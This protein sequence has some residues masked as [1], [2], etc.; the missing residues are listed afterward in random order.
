MKASGNASDSPDPA[1]VGELT[2]PREAEPELRAGRAGLD[3]AP[4][5]AHIGVWEWDV[6]RD[7]LSWVPGPAGIFAATRFGVKPASLPFEL[8]HP[9][10]AGR[11]MAEFKDAI[12]TRTALADEFRVILPGG[13]VRWVSSVGG[14]RYDARGTPLSV[15]G[16]VEDITEKRR[17]E[18]A[19]RARDQLMREA[20]QAARL[21]AWE[22]DLGT[23]ALREIGPVAELFG[24]PPGFVHADLEA[25]RASVHP[26]D[27]ERIWAMLPGG[28]A[29]RATCDVEF[30]T[31]GVDD[32]IRW[33]HAVGRTEYAADGTPLVARG[34]HVDVSDRK[35]AEV[36]LQEG[37]ERFRQLVDSVPHHVWA[38]DLEGHLAYLNRRWIEYTGEV[39]TLADPDSGWRKVVHP[40]DIDRVVEAWARAR[41][42][43]SEY[44]VDLRLRHR[45]GE[46]RWFDVRGT[47]TRDEQGR[48]ARWHGTNTDVHEARTMREA[49]RLEEERLARI[50]ELAPGVILV[51]QRLPD[52]TIRVPYASPGIQELV[53]IPA[54]ELARDASGIRAA[55]HP[56]DLPRAEASAAASA[57]TLSPWRYELRVRHPKRG[58]IWVEIHSMP[59]HDPDGA[60][61]WYGFL[62]DVTQRKRDEGELRNSR[63]QL[64][65]ALEAGGMAPWIYDISK[66]VIS[67]DDAT[68]KLWGR[69]RDELGDGSWATARSFIHPE[70]RLPADSRAAILQSGCR[71]R[72]EFRIR[73]PGGS[74]RWLAIRARVERDAAGE[75]LRLIGVMLD[76]TARKTAEAAQLRSQKLEALGTLAGGIAHDFNNILLAIG[77]N[78]EIGLAD[79][80]P[81][82]PV[83][84]C[85]AEIARASTRATDV[86]RQILAFSGPQDP[87]RR[88]LAPRSVVEEALRL[89]R[90]TIPATVELR[91]DF[92]PDLPAISADAGQIHQ[93]IVNLAT[94]AAA[95]IGSRS[96]R[97]DFRLDAADVGEL[98]RSLPDL[99][100]GRYV[101]LTVSDDGRGM[102][103]ETLEC[104]FDPFFSTK[105]PGQGS[106][107]G[108][109]VVHGIVKSH[110]GAISVASEPGKGATFR[111]YFPAVEGRVAEP[112]RPASEAAPRRH[113]RVLFIDDE[114][115]VVRAAGR[116]FATI[117][118]DATVFSDAA[119]ALEEFRSRPG[120]F[121]V[122]ITDRSMPGVSGF[123]LARDLLAV[124]PDVPILMTT[125]YVHP[126][127]EEI[128]RQ[129][130]VRELI[131]KPF[132]TEQLAR[133]LDRC[134]GRGR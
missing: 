23:G 38:I 3:L 45:D 91:A 125:G 54:E 99:H 20:L 105:P 48:I 14:A 101:R 110:G 74:W 16:T 25:L 132:S 127:D 28:V 71:I 46:Y 10:D 66:D 116:L 80:P 98:A 62:S 130:G 73:L 39:S 67:W 131:P 109:A 57:A 27:G 104:V 129:I 70:D 68:L 30:R 75:P 59:T 36:T 111:L 102:D 8:L 124:R 53:G 34:I 44:H 11:V 4:S 22:A 81:G 120:D 61:L 90:A 1:G 133:A 49:L 88:R 121:D 122:V 82:D 41:A 13:E 86:V 12:A 128:A 51:Y 33:I 84:E 19:S 9:D 77:A 97:I 94:N 7:T 58:E 15:V 117:G 113:G 87:R 17:E 31:R 108:L 107:L 56:D 93:V 118:Y 115:A 18:D 60:M 126:E 76:I 29:P 65:A 26:E 32:E 6:A 96:G 103:P 119:R 69:R 72:N 78:A 35:R 112:P 24:Q 5:A 37:E 2:E 55:I 95:A 47:A 89:L 52:G 79:A 42:G 123:A 85:L 21:V 92:E 50:V 64:A 83:R 134:A 40:D 100:E 106:G 43:D 114:D 63:S